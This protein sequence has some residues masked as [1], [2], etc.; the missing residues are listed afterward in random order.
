[1]FVYASPLRTYT[2]LKEISI[3]F[4]NISAVILPGTKVAPLQSSDCCDEFTTVLNYVEITLNWIFQRWIVKT[5][6]EIEKGKKTLGN[7]LGKIL[8]IVDIFLPEI[9]QFT[10]KYKSLVFFLEKFNMAK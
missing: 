9:D 7:F 10:E 5:E 3:V 8:R 1:M 4:A 2:Y 6:N